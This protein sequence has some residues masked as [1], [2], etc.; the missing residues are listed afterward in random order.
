M[1]VDNIREGQ[2]HRYVRYRQDSSVLEVQGNPMPGGG[3]VYTYQDITQQKR[4]EEALIR[5]ENNIR[6]YTDNVPALIAYF[7]KECRYLFTNRAYEQAFGIDR[8]AVI[9]KRFEEVMPR[10]MAD[11][12]LPWMRRH[13]P[14][15]GSASRSPSVTTRAAPVTCWSPI[16]RTSATAA[17]S[18]VSSPSIRTSP[19]AGWPR[20]PSRRPTRILEERVRERTQ[21]LS[22]A[23]AALR[24]E[25]RVR[26]EAELALRQAK[27]LA[28]DANASKTR[29]LAAAS[30]DLLQPLNA[31]RLFT[32]A[33]AQQ[34]D[35]DDPSA[36]SAI[37]ITPCRPPRS[38]S[39]PC[40]TSPSW[41]PGP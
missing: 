17:P 14:A 3:F 29:F 22:E 7:D 37:S 5:S 30:H 31:A 27:Q 1:L 15:S 35:A 11:E 33:L 18:S 10:H 32:S 9:G 34:D 25:N 8:N 19:N 2:P 6:I 21:A 28:E 40:S 41:M 26:A 4:I 20:L 38:C 23:N 16:R 39:A 13:C 12:G 24:Q 36:P